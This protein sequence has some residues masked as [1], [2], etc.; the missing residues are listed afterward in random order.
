MYRFFFAI[1]IS[2]FFF[3]ACSSPK[4]ETE[5]EQNPQ[6]QTDTPPQTD[7]KASRPSP[8][9]VFE[10]S[11]QGAYV[12]IDYSS[13]GVKG[14]KIWGELVKYGEVWRTGANEATV[15]M[16]DKPVLFEGEPLP[17]GRYGFFTIPQPDNWTIIINSSPTSGV[18]LSM[19]RRRMC[20][21]CR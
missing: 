11:I 6:A 3:Q 18:P 19:T 17:A 4:T 5:E 8:P 9:K 7:E 1:I 12:R 2:L 16:V 20:F 15:L 13:P 14:R 10:D 21:G